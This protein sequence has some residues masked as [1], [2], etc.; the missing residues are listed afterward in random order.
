MFI[1]SKIVSCQLLDMLI[2]KSRNP[3][4][5]RIFGSQK[6]IPESEEKLKSSTMYA[7]VDGT[8]LLSKSVCSQCLYVFGFMAPYE[9]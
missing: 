4:S 9:V 7:L 3:V 1:K 8:L 5:F 6:S 2:I